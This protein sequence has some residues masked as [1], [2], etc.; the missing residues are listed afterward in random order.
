MVAITSR[1]DLERW[2]RDQPREVSVGIAARA[3]L[4]V[5][6]L[7][8]S[9]FEAQRRRKKSPRAVSTD[10]VLPAIRAMALPLAAAE[11]PAK[12][13]AIA[14]ITGKTMSVETPVKL[15]VRRRGASKASA[16]SGR[17]RSAARAAIPTD[18]SRDTSRG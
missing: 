7:L 17:T 9:A 14:R 11:Y 13:N 6:P 12:G 15:F 18:I 10:I 2:L 5:L 16:S 1:E 3:A 8:A 4:R